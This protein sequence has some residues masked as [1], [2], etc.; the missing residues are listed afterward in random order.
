LIDLV[1]FS[2]GPIGVAASRSWSI[3][4]LRV[5]YSTRLQIRSVKQKKNRTFDRYSRRVI[6]E[7]VCPWVRRHP[8][9]GIEVAAPEPRLDRG[10]CLVGRP[11]WPRAVRSAAPGAIAALSVD[12]R[13]SP[14]SSECS[15]RACVAC[16]CQLL[17]VTTKGGIRQR[18]FH[19]CFEIRCVSKQAKEWNY[20]AIFNY[21][22]LFTAVH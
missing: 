21:W 13:Q 18:L 1:R 2:P 14:W 3:A 22:K 11:I 16:S 6:A 10:F 4:V 9:P 5:R 19:L 7:I 12:R 15:R 17:R 8:R 20:S